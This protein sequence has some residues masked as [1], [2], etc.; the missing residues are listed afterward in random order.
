[1]SKRI[2]EAKKRFIREKKYIDELYDKLR[3]TKIKCPRCE[4]ESNVDPFALEINCECLL[5]E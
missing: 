5:D 2:E 1:M 3:P 4:K